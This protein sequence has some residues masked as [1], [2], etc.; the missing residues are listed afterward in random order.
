[1]T[2][3]GSPGGEGWDGS[4]SSNDSS[5]VIDNRPRLMIDSRLSARQTNCPRP[6]EVQDGGKGKRENE[7]KKK[8]SEIERAE[9]RRKLTASLCQALSK[10]QWIC[11]F[12]LPMHTPTSSGYPALD[13]WYIQA[14]KKVLR[15]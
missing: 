11:C 15:C 14:L 3:R 9:G 2:A 5:I 8:A 13:H 10:T 12:S 1:M 6:S 7:K 4:R